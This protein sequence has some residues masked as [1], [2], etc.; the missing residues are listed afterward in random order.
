[1]FNP[2]YLS[3]LVLSSQLTPLLTKVNTYYKSQKQIISKL[4]YALKNYYRNVQTVCQNL[5]EISKNFE[6]LE[7]LTIDINIE[8]EISK[9]YE[10]LK[11]FFKERKKISENENE[12]IHDKIKG[13][14]KI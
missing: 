7:K 8:K 10:M 2:K 12:I 1:M 11:I 13:F 9:A 3:L 6:E 4:S 5:E 14:I